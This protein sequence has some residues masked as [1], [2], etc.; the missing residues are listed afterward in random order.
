L[1]SYIFKHTYEHVTSVVPCGLDGAWQD[2][3]TRSVWARVIYLP[4][5]QT[6]M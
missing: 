3:K 4:Q 2:H 5:Q 6:D 1:S